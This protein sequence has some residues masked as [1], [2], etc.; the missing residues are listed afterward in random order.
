MPI[1]T[2]NFII[3][4]AISNEKRI[5]FTFLDIVQ[6]EHFKLNPSQNIKILGTASL[7]VPTSTI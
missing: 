5:Q 4:Y 3:K 7:S 6:E 1:L 2:S